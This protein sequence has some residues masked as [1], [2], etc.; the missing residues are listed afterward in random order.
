MAGALL[1]Q[2]TSRSNVSAGAMLAF[3][4]A[5]TVGWQGDRFP[6]YTQGRHCH[7]GPTVYVFVQFNLRDQRACVRVGSGHAE[8]V[9]VP[10]CWLRDP[11]FAARRFAR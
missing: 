6:I 3:S 1:A 10:F 11:K 8:P 2:S 9:A 7:S 4:V 5:L